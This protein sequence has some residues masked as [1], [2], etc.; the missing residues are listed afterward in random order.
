MITQVTSDIHRRHNSESVLR[1]FFRRREN[2]TTQRRK[3]LQSERKNV[4]E[5]PK[6]GEAN[7]RG[8][9]AATGEGGTQTE[10]AGLGGGVGRGGGDGRALLE[11]AAAPA[12]SLQSCPTLCDP[13]DGSPPGSPVPGILQARVLEWGSISLSNA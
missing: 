7:R 10:W 5:E 11:R 4:E 3:R 13:I 12:G 1:P 8:G 9:G 6:E 2:V